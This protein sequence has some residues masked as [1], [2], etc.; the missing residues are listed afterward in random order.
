MGGWA[1]CKI[2]FNGAGRKARAA[3]TRMSNKKEMRNNRAKKMAMADVEQNE[4]ETALRKSGQELVVV[5]N[6]D[7][8]P[9]D[10]RK[11]KTA[12][13]AEGS[14]RGIGIT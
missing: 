11:Y 5:G 9:F 4:M 12:G 1:E 3:P 14:G 7:V 13:E 10:G 6:R 2:E 8:A